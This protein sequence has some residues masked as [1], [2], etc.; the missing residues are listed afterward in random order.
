M[1]FNIEDE[2]LVEAPIDIFNYP[3]EISAIIEE[4][5]KTKFL[6]WTIIE[7]ATTVRSE[8]VAKLIITTIIS[9]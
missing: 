1:V 8:N 2:I 3:T 9:L 5:T 6:E 4:F 7:L